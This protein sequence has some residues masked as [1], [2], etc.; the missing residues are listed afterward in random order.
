VVERSFKATEREGKVYGRGTA[1]MKAFLAC[2]IAVAREFSHARY[3]RPVHLAFSFDEELGCLGVPLLIEA[4]RTSLQ[5][6]ALCV[7]GEPTSMR[8]VL[9]H[10][11][12]YVLDTRF[13]GIDCHSS[14]SHKGVSAIV[15]AAQFIS[16]VTRYFENVR[17]QEETAGT[18][19]MTSFNVGTIEGGSALNI[20]P[21][22]CRACW[23]F[24]PFPLTDAQRILGDIDRLIQEEV[25]G[26]M[27]RLHTTPA[28][29]STIVARVPALIPDRDS[30]VFG[31]LLSLGGLELGEMVN[32]GTEAGFFQQ[33]GIPTA[34][35]GP[36][37]IDQ[38]HRADEF[39]DIHH[40]DRCLDMISHLVQQN[41]D[42]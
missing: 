34:V 11:G 29:R 40:V 42:H 39:V 20:V 5:R 2:C 23:E 25:L 41:L 1:D 4:G 12:V 35:C 32:F 8:L 21:R 13:E 3:T 9:G 27:R 30:A 18:R 33:L 17:V 7:V 15:H 10:K 28:I 14:E 26:S 36:G 22:H 37:A 16:S 31:G 6:A 24:R 19:P 38:A